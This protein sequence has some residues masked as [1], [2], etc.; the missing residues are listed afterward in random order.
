[1]R[2]SLF[3]S[4]PFSFFNFSFFVRLFSF[5]HPPIHRRKER[6]MVR[7]RT[8]GNER[9]LLSIIRESVC[10]WSGGFSAVFSL[11]NFFFSRFLLLWYRHLLCKNLVPFY[12]EIRE[13]RRRGKTTFPL[14]KYVDKILK[15]KL[16]DKEYR[17]TE[18][19]PNSPKCS[20]LHLDRCS[21]LTMGRSSI[22]VYLFYCELFNFCNL[23]LMLY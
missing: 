2:V 1:M 6:E 3:F 15:R 23:N 11:W 10:F 8:S 20:R 21:L 13:R 14:L 4:T 7:K 16:T 17:S 5:C 12:G 18:S 9:L 22:H 19:W